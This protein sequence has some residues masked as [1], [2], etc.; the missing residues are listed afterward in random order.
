MPSVELSIVTF[1]QALRSRQEVGHSS[2]KLGH[3]HALVPRC[4]QTEIGPD[5]L[6]HLE[7]FVVRKHVQS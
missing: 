4:P 1:E 6:D 5:A 3:S 2:Q 7:H